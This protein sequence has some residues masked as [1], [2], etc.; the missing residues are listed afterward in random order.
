MLVS[1]YLVKGVRTSLRFARVYVPPLFSIILFTF[2]IAL[3]LYSF[4]KFTNHVCCKFNGLNFYGE[5]W[6]LK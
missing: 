5:L 1:Y 4:Q 2:Y 6:N 3:Q